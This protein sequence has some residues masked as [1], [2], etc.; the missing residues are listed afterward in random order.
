[1]ASK[2]SFVE[3]ELHAIETISKATPALRR[4]I[5][6]NSSEQL[7]EALC[8]IAHNYVSSNI[9]CKPEHYEDLK[10]YQDTLRFL[11]TPV[12]EGQAYSDSIQEK[13]AALMLKGDN[14]WMTFILP[15]VYDLCT[16][17]VSKIIKRP[18]IPCGPVSPTPIPTPKS[19]KKNNY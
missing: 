8:E 9:E 19:L 5:L 14:F 3:D 2:K 17:F 11:A 12:R 6:A 4:A 13:R 1:M 10:K 18:S 16:H 15:L 7:I